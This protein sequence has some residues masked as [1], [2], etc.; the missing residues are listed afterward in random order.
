MKPGAGFGLLLT[1]A[2]A[3]SCGPGTPAYD[4]VLRGGT[5]VDGSG[6]PPRPADV[7]ILG[8]HIVAVGDE[9]AG[10]GAEE[11]DISGLTVAPG[12]W[13]NHA[14]LVE[15]ED[16]P[17]AENFIRQG[18]TTISAALH[19]QAQV[20][21]IPAY[22]ERVRMGP[23]VM[24]FAGHT[25]AR[26]RVMGRED[27]APKE[28]ELAAMAALV[29]EA[30]EGGAF[31]L[32]TGLEYVPAVY[33]E[34]DEIVRLA[35]EVRPYGGMYV[36]HLRDEGVRVNEAVMEALRVGREA[37]I[38]VLI[39]HHKVTGAAQ[40]GGTEQ[41]LGLIEAAVDAGQVV[42]LD[43][44][45]YT[46]YSTYSDLMFP[47]W[48]L[49]GSA[50]DFAQRVADPTTRARLVREMLAR[51]P[52][53]AGRDGDSIQFR[54]VPGQ[55][56][57]TGR[58]LADYV[59]ARG[60]G[61]GLEGAVAALIELQLAGGFIGIFHGMDD[62]DIRRLMRHPLTM[63]ETDGD[64]VTPGEGFPHPRSYGSFP[65]VLGHYVRD[66]GVLTLEAAVHKMTQ[67]AADWYGQSDRG[68]IVAGAIADLTV[69]DAVTISDEAR[70][71]DPHHYPQGVEH[72]I[73]NGRPVLR[74]GAM[75]DELPGVFLA[76]PPPP[77]RERP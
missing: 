71:T 50:D 51:F 68:R 49:A 52:E 73:V 59:A 64:L 31:G 61:S 34:T 55:P 24:L 29:R 12:F 22:R 37:G 8:T 25:W 35:T 6:S 27:R 48:A 56:E 20:E 47:P 67:Q 40:F 38:P 77:E 4:L 10:T 23:N 32:S 28:S 75:T 53:Q 19:S 3:T 39:N 70:Y 46:A 72:V 42:A 33:A 45:P 2:L 21:D 69:F 15:L 18:I 13:D 54:E 66:E 17:D 16:R 76:P 58:T 9:V 30:M 5:L 63:F 26:E 14:H 62:G 11:L 1:A 41:T 65:R 7:A 43:V 44:Y 74:A 60:L 36:T 57:L